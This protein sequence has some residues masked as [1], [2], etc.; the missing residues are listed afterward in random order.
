VSELIITAF[1]TE[2]AAMA[3]RDALIALQLAAKTELEDVILV[4]RRAEGEIT[5]EQA[6][7]KATG[8]PLGDG[9]WGLLIGSLFLDERDPKKQKNRGLAA[10][11]RRTGLDLEFI[12]DVSGALV[13]GGAAVGMR[14][15]ALPPK[16]VIARLAS[17]DVPGR[18]MRAT[19]SAEVEA[20][21]ETLCD[22]IPDFS[23]ALSD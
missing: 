9:R 19:L 5:L 17:L 23:A 4:I 3:A 7:W 18:V 12:R 13:S 14:T 16:T 1:P 8:K 15:R 10:L 6:A 11:F 21:L 22:V 2:A 20:E